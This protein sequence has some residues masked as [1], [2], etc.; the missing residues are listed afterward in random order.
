MRMPFGAMT[1]WLPKYTDEAAG[2]T[3]AVAALLLLLLVYELREGKEAGPRE[4]VLECGGVEPLCVLPC[5]VASSVD[6]SSCAM[7]RL[8]LSSCR[9]PVMCVGYQMSNTLRVPAAETNVL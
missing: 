3:C 8:K 5:E 4:P 6:F 2:L 7:Y 9:T 1:Q